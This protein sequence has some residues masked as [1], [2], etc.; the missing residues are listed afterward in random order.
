MRLWRLCTAGRGGWSGWKGADAG[1]IW[2]CWCW[3]WW[4]SR[5]LRAESTRQRNPSVHFVKSWWA[6]IPQP[7]SCG[8]L[9]QIVDTRTQWSFLNPRGPTT[10]TPPPFCSPP[11][12]C[13][14]RT[15]VNLQTKTFYVQ[16]HIKHNI[17]NFIINNNNNRNILIHIY[18]KHIF[19]FYSHN[20]DG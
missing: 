5:G 16:K 10:Q 1:W 6:E 18:E 20:I 15:V 19:T 9:P 8:L 13:D 4:G 12:P 3:C 7:A 11:W 14:T 17:F 2:W